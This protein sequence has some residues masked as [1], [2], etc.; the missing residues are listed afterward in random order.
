MLAGSGLSWRAG[1]THEVRAGDCLVYLPSAG[2]HTLIA[3]DEPMDVLAFGERRPVELAHLP[4][5]GVLWAGPS[6]VADAVA[7]GEP[8]ERE[9]AAGPLALPVAVS[10]RPDWIVNRDDVEIPEVV[11]PGRRYRARRLG[12]AAGGVTSGLRHLAIAPGEN[13]YPRHCHSAEEELFVILGGSG[14]V[15]VGDEEAPV[16][17]GHVLARPA[18]TGLAHSFRAG[19]EGLECLAYGQRDTNDIVYY[20]DSRKVSFAGIGVIGRIE[21]LDYWDGEDLPA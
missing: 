8:W 9:A 18:G 16:R 5:A 12:V 6:W 21:P 2:A 13:G 15:R 10:P 17:A 1:E 4:R 14:T 3:G 20:P 11:R 19:P 7:A